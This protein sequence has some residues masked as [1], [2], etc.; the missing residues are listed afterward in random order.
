MNLLKPYL[1]TL[2]EIATNEK[3]IHVAEVGKQIPFDVKRT[4]WITPAI[5]KLEVG[6]HAHRKLSQVFVAVAGKIEVSLTDV[7]GNEQSFV[8]DSSSTGLFVPPLFWKKLIFSPD[9]I[10]VCLT[11]HLYEEDD[12]IKNLSDFFSLGR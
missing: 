7:S 6:N 5:P 9:A 8:L 10:L 2:Q 4:Y 3:A 12:Y 11:S 1:I